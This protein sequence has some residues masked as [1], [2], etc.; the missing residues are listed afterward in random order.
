VAQGN[1]GAPGDVAV[2]EERGVTYAEFRDNSAQRVCVGQGLCTLARP[3]VV[4]GSYS[5][6]TQC[7]IESMDYAPPAHRD[8]EGQLVFPAGATVTVNVSCLRF[9]EPQDGGTDNGGTDPANP[10]PNPDGGNPAGESTAPVT[11][12]QPQ[13]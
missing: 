2:F 7:P 11:G 1:P 10:N 4:E 8:A 3:N 6:P 13:A 12:D 9:S 5:D